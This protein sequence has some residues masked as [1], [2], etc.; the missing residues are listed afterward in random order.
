MV[1][2]IASF[3][4]DCGFLT[5]LRVFLVLLEAGEGLLT[6][7]RRRENGEGLSR[8]EIDPEAEEVRVVD[9]P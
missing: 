6:P 1:S 3:R 7:T 4:G 8:L 5:A 2:V 9:Y